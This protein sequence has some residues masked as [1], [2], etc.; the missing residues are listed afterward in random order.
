MFALDL[1]NT[2]Y[3]RELREGAVDN[4]I[5]RLIEPLSLRAADIRTQLR[6][7]NLR[8]MQ[9]QALEKEYEDL[10]QKR[11]DIIHGRKPAA[12]EFKKH[13]YK[14]NEFDT[15][16]PQE[17]CM[18][19][20]TL[21]ETEEEWYDEHGRPSEHGCYDAG[22]HYHA[23]REPDFDAGYDA[24]KERQYTDEA[25]L[26]DVADKQAKMA[27]LNQPG[28]VGTDVVT[29]QQR[30]NPNPNK[31]VVG[32][33][34]D[35]LRGKGG[36]G[37]EG[38]TYESELDEAYG[39]VGS[40]ALMNGN[41]AE[42]L[43]RR[44][45]REPYDMDFG[46]EKIRITP[47][48][49]DAIA[50][51]YMDDKN[52]SDASPKNR[53][54]K[55]NAV[56]NY[57]AFGYPD[58]MKQLI[59][60]VATPGDTPAPG[61]P[62]EQ[63]PLIE[64]SQRV[65]K[66]NSKKDPELTGTTA[67]DSTVRRELQKVR[68]R[69]PSARSDIEALV[70]DEI[71]NQERVDQMLS[72]QQSANQ[73]QTAQISQLTRANQ[74][75][76]TKINSLQKQLATA[77]QT[78]KPVPSPTASAVKKPVTTAPTVS[79]TPATAT[80]TTSPEPVIAYDQELRNKVQQ[81]DDL[82]KTATMAALKRPNDKDTQAEL[83]KR[84]D[85]LQKQI[86]KLNKK[87]ASKK[88]KK[89][90]Y[91]KVQKPVTGKEAPALP[92]PNVID[93]DAFE[94]PTMDIPKQ[95]DLVGTVPN[96]DTAQNDRPEE[97]QKAAEGI[98][99]PT[100]IGQMAKNVGQGQ[101]LQ[102]DPAY[103]SQ[104]RRTQQQVSQRQRN[105]ARGQAGYG[106]DPDEF[107]DIPD[108]NETIEPG[109]EI[110]TNQLL[111]RAAVEYM[112]HMGREGRPVDYETAIKLAAKHYGIPYRP[113][114]VPEL[115]AK[116]QELDAK[117]AAAI[118][119]KQAERA[120]RRAK[121]LA[122]TAPT[123]PEQEKKMQ[124]FWSKHAPRADRLKGSATSLEEVAK[125]DFRK[126]AEKQQGTTID[127]IKNSNYPDIVKKYLIAINDPAGPV[128]RAAYRSYSKGHEA[129]EQLR[130][131]FA[132]K[133]NVDPSEFENAELGMMAKTLHGVKE[134]AM[135]ELDIERQDLERMTDPQFLKAYGISKEFWKY[136]N[137]AVLKKPARRPMSTQLARSPVGKK[138]NAMYGSTCP[139]CGNST[140]PDRCVCEGYQDFKKVEPYAV[141]L[142]GKPVKKFDYYEQAR[143]FHDNWKKKLYR[144]GNKEKADKITLMPIMDEGIK[145]RLAGAALAGATAL[146]GA[147]AAV[148]DAGALQQAMKQQVSTKSQLPKP[149]A[150]KVKADEP[151]PSYPK[152][153]SYS[154]DEST[155]K[156]YKP[157]QYREAANPAQQAAIAINMKKHHIKPKHVSEDVIPSKMVTQGFVVEYD[158]ATQTVTISK[159]GQELDRFSFK[160]QPNL[161]SFQRTIAKR[162]KD[163]EDD[164]YGADQEPGVVSLSRMKVPG[165]G[166]GYQ[167][168]GEDNAS[169]PA[170]RAILNRI[171][172]AHKDLL[173]K[174]GPQKVMQAV[175]EVAYN[176]GD[177][178]EIGTSDVSAW[179][180]EVKQILGAE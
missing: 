129:K 67:Q 7:G 167:E 60:S 145:S 92:D 62:G 86:E 101:E 41:F 37:K 88:K 57:R 96:D 152:T 106:N 134:G 20:G 131:A 103:R 94:I 90:T 151:A 120:G 163:L 3:E 26:P 124:D 110:S 143:Q 56:N 28:K 14:K 100:G 155:L 69:H 176:V 87:S 99:K 102:K 178:D 16:K 111:Y 170:E 43:K 55:Q 159:R 118:A 169:A 23:D 113:G 66:K 8:P 119:A 5:A 112:Q 13:A 157:E 142:A 82:M 33:A 116:R 19:Y 51:K 30:V 140:N 34:A 75:Q 79:I 22:G 65:Q 46:S 93:V 136:K 68:A 161:T 80:T 50:K 109:E 29:P 49:M 105:I 44:A 71:V 18:G 156:V 17:E 180:N 35:W 70:K 10:V 54:L 147:H 81:L 72:Q 98:E 122:R 114:M 9:I 31:G 58:L 21:G 160:G 117:L 24:Y 177:V 141:C 125:S 74:Q 48:L 104:V 95:D 40:K 132:K 168:L 76:D 36:P 146:G 153:S 123:T 135:S 42:F 85:D 11:L 139:G 154:D 130:N 77:I 73:Q 53:D 158:P 83:N 133:Y 162:V 128:F 91:K 25:G 138:M 64:K 32:H 165:R 61:E 38:P 63:L 27:R 127:K 78:M 15:T 164:L 4:T 121:Q 89:M 172:V 179:V 52:A 12:P 171:M 108:M 2:T 97:L 39:T 47:A 148:P 6:N 115:H 166:Y 173:I 45:S 144:E 174:F 59:A 126:Y 149:Q 107:D 150:P 137:Q 84:I 1:F 175:E